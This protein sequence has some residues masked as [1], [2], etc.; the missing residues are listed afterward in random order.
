MSSLRDGTQ[1]TGRPTRFASQPSN[2]SSGDGRA[3]APKLP[4]TSREITRTWSFSSPNI[5][6]MAALTG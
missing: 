1:I 3:L 2:A 5:E 4:P 6:A